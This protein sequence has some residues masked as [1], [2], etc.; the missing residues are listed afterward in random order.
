MSFNG[1]MFEKKEDNKRKFMNIKPPTPE[2]TF[3]VYINLVPAESADARTLPVTLGPEIGP[4]P[5][6]RVTIDSFSFG[7]RKKSK[8]F[9]KRAACLVFLNSSA[10]IR[11]EK[12]E[13]IEKCAR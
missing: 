8:K 9:F 1:V 4:E 10:M 2:A 6:F 11:I 7:R 13:R 3:F 5:R 12:G